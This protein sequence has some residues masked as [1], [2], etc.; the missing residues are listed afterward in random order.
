MANGMPKKDG[1]FVKGSIP[2][3]KITLP[4]EDL[5]KIYS[6]LGS[7]ITAI[8]FGV[9]KHTV[10]R[11][12]RNYNIKTRGSGA[13]ALMPASWKQALH[14]PKS[15]PAW[16]KGQTKETNAS[17]NRIAEALKGTNNPQ[18]KSELHTDEKVECSC[19]CGE[20]IL[21]FDKKGRRRYYKPSHCSTGFFKKGS[22]TWNK[23][24]RWDSDVVK[25]MLTR[26]TPN[27]Q[28]AFLSNFFAIHNLPYRFVGDGAIII[29]GRNPD[30]INCN[31]QKKIIEFF[32][33]Y[34]H[35]LD[36]EGV[37]RK[38]YARYGYTMLG[39]WGKDIKNE[40]KLLEVVSNFDRS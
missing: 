5:E 12:L 13:P 1:R 35:K 4:R 27:K 23:G 26:R 20:L 11:N 36:D 39:I 40:K 8:H 19:G 14:K 25:K 16:N 18:W 21:K 31:G 3:N 6:K 9:S 22:V 33:E 38:I 17:V 30:F 7:R 10:L 32:G 29:E 28:E 15:V 2:T 34:W 24:K 37:K